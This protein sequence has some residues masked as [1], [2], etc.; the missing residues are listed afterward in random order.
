[1]SLEKNNK[2]NFIGIDLGTTNTSAHCVSLNSRTGSLIVKE[3]E[4]Q[5][6]VNEGSLMYERLLP[7]V[8][9]LDGKTGISYIGKYAK[10]CI[11]RQ[12]EEHSFGVE[13]VKLKM[14][15][16]FQYSTPNGMKYTP[17]DIS[18]M[19]LKQIY[20]AIHDLPP[21]DYLKG[22]VVVTIPASFDLAQRQATKRA[23]EIAGFKDIKLLEEPKAAL[24]DCIYSALYEDHAEDKFYDM[25]DSKQ[26][27]IMVYDIGGGT[28]DVTLHLLKYNHPFDII[29]EDLAIGR[30]T[31]LGG[32]AIDNIVSK[33]IPEHFFGEKKID[34][35]LKRLREVSESLK[36]NIFNKYKN[37]KVREGKAPSNVEVEFY[38]VN[39][40]T[41]NFAVNSI[42]DWETFNQW[43]SD[44]IIDSNFK[45]IKD[46]YYKGEN[47]Q[48]KLKSF[49][50]P[51]VDIFSRFYGQDI[52]YKHFENKLNRWQEPDIVLLNGG[53]SYFPTVEQEIRKFFSEDVYIIDWGN[54]DLAVSRGAALYNYLLE[55]EQIRKSIISENY[56]LK[57]EGAEGKDRVPLIKEGTVFD[58]IDGYIE[59]D[60][61][62]FCIRAETDALKIQC[63]KHNP[64]EQEER[65]IDYQ[66]EVNKSSED[67]PVGLYWELNHD[68]IFVLGIQDLKTEKTIG[69]FEPNI[70]KGL[71]FTED[72][73]KNILISAEERYTDEPMEILCAKDA[74]E[75]DINSTLK[76]WQNV[77]Y[78]APFPYDR[79]Q[80]WSSKEM[81]PKIIKANNW[82]E[83]IPEIMNRIYNMI[84]L[85]KQK[86]KNKKNNIK[87]EF[88]NLLLSI[89][90][91]LVPLYRLASKLK[92]D[93][94]LRM[95]I[96]NLLMEL[97]DE[98][99]W[100]EY[101]PKQK[102]NTYIQVVGQ[103]AVVAMGMISERRPNKYGIYMK[104]K[105]SIFCEDLLLK[106]IR[107]D[108]AT[109]GFQLTCLTSLGKCGSDKFVKF[110]AENNY[111]DPEY[112]LIANFD[113]SY[114]PAWG[115]TISW[116]IGK[117]GSRL[118]NEP[119]QIS[120]ELKNILNQMMIELKNQNSG[121]MRQN[122]L[123]FALGQI[124][125]SCPDIPKEYL[126]EEELRNNALN[127]INEYGSRF[128][129]SETLVKGVV[130]RLEG[131]AR[132]ETSEVHSEYKDTEAAFLKMVNKE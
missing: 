5:Q 129:A 6:W 90:R 111:P 66:I 64:G 39:P 32:T 117:I 8:V 45:T 7:S 38:G 103:T 99:R 106:I 34:Y 115:D 119:I 13:E 78:N 76:S 24:I 4:I 84:G 62:N 19:I 43:I 85:L 1:M 22:C 125:D 110:V 65:L 16:A 41:S 68:K 12:Q 18:G 94:A 109:R 80:S 77:L 98:E 57:V 35:D 40:V 15:Q 33:Y 104:T 132:K 87:T 20:K 23:C 123:L 49:L 70:T 102:W 17:E 127:Y 74:D 75:L 108:S 26:Q 79:D 100:K 121:K 86:R 128:D 53:M 2:K 31:E 36:I 59:K 3:I 51:V 63:F 69:I 50:G 96:G 81:E 9:Y 72:N 131:K 130:A 92:T 48:T 73:P 116:A 105:Y 114:Q 71:N 46:K 88:R 14:G 118:N 61:K 54:R 29:I 37:K 126:L 124:L 55:K 107:Q 58:L 122:F 113:E 101:I 67:L 21:S 11:I 95:R 42:L 47:I 120:S 28:L 27:M 56:Y 89:Q 112:K 93:D 97:V 30:Y 44:F 82:K 52:C 83:F 91:F 60:L 10:Q 25:I